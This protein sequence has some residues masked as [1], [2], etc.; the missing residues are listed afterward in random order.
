[1]DFKK[2][3]KTRLYVAITYIVLGIILIGWGFFAQTN[4]NYMSYLGLA[5]AVIGCVRI[6]NYV[7]ITRNDESIK[8]QQIAETDERNI[9]IM[10]KA[11]SAAF[12]IYILISCAVVITLSVLNLHDIAKWIG[13]SVLSLVVIYWICYWVYQRK[14]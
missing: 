9:S 2:K 5:L 11:R 4:N 6:R 12:F 1:M 13:Y 14:L 3:L 8:K 7:I 10:H